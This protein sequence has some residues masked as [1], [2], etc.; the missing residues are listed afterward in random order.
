MSAQPWTVQRVLLLAEEYLRERGRSS[1]GLRSDLSRALGAVL[2]LD[3][4]HLLLQYDRI[5]SSEERA[6]F[7]EFTRRLAE[8]EPLAYLLGKR[9]FFGRPFGVGPDV[10][11]PRPETELL[12]EKALEVLP[13][14]ARVFE[15]CTGSGCIGISLVLEREDLQ[16]LASDVS[17]K[18][19]A[20]ARRNAEALGVDAERFRL[21]EGSF[22]EVAEGERF[23]ALLAN[24]PYVDPA[25]P[26]LLDE[27]VRDF[28]PHLALFGPRGDP[29]GAYREL[30]KGGVD[31]LVGGAWVL[32]ELGVDTAARVLD[33]VR[34][35]RSYTGGQVLPDLAGN[36]RLLLARRK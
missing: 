18:A 5:L 25:R 33:W 7:R 9:E 36:P 20:Q 12:V 28:E 24:P 26:E 29:L 11:I 32:M 16:V 2:G 3:R 21:R 22:W 13:R 1:L 10:L 27:G 8:G 34:R 4:L 23:D 19:L 30:L 6:K 14:G 35:S 15:P 31:G 17:A